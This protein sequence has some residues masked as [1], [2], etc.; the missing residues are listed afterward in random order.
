M[1]ILSS[2]FIGSS[3]ENDTS[4]GKFISTLPPNLVISGFRIKSIE[5]PLT[6]LTEW[7]YF[8]YPKPSSLLV[9]FS[10]PIL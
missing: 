5:C 3:T 10:N 8:K 7:Y 9:F 2:P 4:S 6:N 1:V